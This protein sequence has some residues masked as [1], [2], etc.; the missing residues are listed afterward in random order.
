M[1]IASSGMFGLTVEKILNKTQT[2]D[3]EAN[4]NVKILMVRDTFT[5]AFDTHDFR[6]D[7]TSEVTAGN[8]YTAGGMLVTTNVITVGSPAAGQIKYD[9]T[10]DPAWV[11]ST[12][13]SAMAAI[14]YFST[15]TTTT[16]QLI[17]LADF[18]TAASSDNGTFTIQVHANGWLYIDYVA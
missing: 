17:Y 3:L 15:G 13:T 6:D 12:I 4:N 7:V 10:T 14:H 2:G 5:P 8:G 9:T 18:V 1:A 11:T 16:D